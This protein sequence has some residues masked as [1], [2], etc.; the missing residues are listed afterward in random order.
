MMRT[1]RI[2]RLL[3][4]EVALDWSWW[5]SSAFVAWTLV[6]EGASLLPWLGPFR[7]ALVGVAGV[8]GLVASVAW[9]E[10][11]HGWIA[12]ACGV[13]VRHVTLFLFGGITDVERAP[14]SPRSELFTALTA[15]LASLLVGALLVGA[16]AMT[17]GPLP[18]GLDDFHRLGAPGALLA[19]LAVVNFGVA[20]LNL[21][22]AFPL[23]GGRVVRA[24]V[25]K[26][27]GDMDA[28]TR[29]A[30]LGGQLFGWLAVLLGFAI[31]FARPGGL[32][33]GVGLWTAFLGWFLASGAARSYEEVRV[34]DALAHVRVGR[35]M[36]RSFAAIPADLPVA[37]AMRTFLARS[38]GGP[39]PIVDGDELIGSLA[40]RDV[41]GV[42]PSAWAVTLVRDLAPA[43][44]EGVVTARTP[45]STAL[46]MLRESGVDRVWVVSRGGARRRGGPRRARI[47]GV[48]HREDVARWVS[49]RAGAGTMRREP[50]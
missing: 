38:E 33:I 28:G 37:T 31:A 13:P 9:H 24:L 43:V 45:V 3:G 35:L 27:T 10:I 30:A 18:R 11:A 41:R 48:L 34:Q 40:Y 39:L 47:V 5:V 25:W 12:R 1:L 7:I 19:W 4:V 16:L 6:S 46:A 29:W 42:P 17:G 23:D 49:A 15:P 22:P 8:M 20:A 26:A 44:T 50:A 14:R 21:L 32:G 36:R 2:G